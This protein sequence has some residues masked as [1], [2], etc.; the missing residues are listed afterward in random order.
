MDPLNIPSGPAVDAPKPVD[1][2]ATPFVLPSESPTVVEPAPVAPVVNDDGLTDDQR[3]IKQL[4][5]EVAATQRIAELEAQ[6]RKVQDERAEAAIIAPVAQE[7]IEPRGTID[8]IGNWRP[9]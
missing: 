7:D 8:G 5:A 9:G 2:G 4:E 3:R 1:T 6:L